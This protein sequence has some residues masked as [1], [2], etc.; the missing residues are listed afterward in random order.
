MPKITLIFVKILILIYTGILTYHF[1]RINSDTAI[2]IAQSVSYLNNNDFTQGITQSRDIA[3]S[4]Y[5][6]DT[7]FAPGVQYVMVLLLNFMSLRIAL[8]LSSIAALIIIYESAWFII[9]FFAPQINIS[10][11]F[12]FV[13]FFLFAPILF[14]YCGLSDLISLGFLLLSIVFVLKISNAKELRS[15]NIALAVCLGI[16]AYLTCFFRYAYYFFF[17]IP[18][19]VLGL[20]ALN[21]KQLWRFFSLAVLTTLVLLFVQLLQRS[22]VG[23]IK[24]RHT[25]EKHL[26]WED[27]SLTTNFIT[28]SFYDSEILRVLFSKVLPS[29]WVSH[30]VIILQLTTVALFLW[31]VVQMLKVLINTL[32]I[33]QKQGINIK[34]SLSTRLPSFMAFFFITTLANIFIIMTLTVVLGRYYYTTGGFWT[35]VEEKRYFAPLALTIWIIMTVAM[36]YLTKVRWQRYIIA[37]IAILCIICGSVQNGAKLRDYYKYKEARDLYYMSDQIYND[38]AKTRIFVTPQFGKNY[39]D[40][41]SMAGASLCHLDS[42]SSLK[43][44]Y[45]KPIVIYIPI[46]TMSLS[47]A[48]KYRLESLVKIT[49]AKPWMK[50]R[51]YG[52]TTLYRASLNN[53]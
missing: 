16:A 31:V 33:Y 25:G 12:V 21:N 37:F 14:Q 19:F 15:V 45:S 29:T 8:W 51:S 7:T 44:T 18:F 30:S 1:P 26:Y 46:S 49:E 38:G 34:Q 47:T 27:L 50:I 10:Q 9:R 39:A 42:I 22:G 13:F 40:Y 48:D 23:Y 3:K 11:F 20:F 2:Q 36:S 4:R 28:D 24:D 5:V 32:T 53:Q 17:W 6:Y 52:T 43:L 41:A 35:Y